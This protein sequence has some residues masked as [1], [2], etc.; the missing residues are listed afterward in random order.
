MLFV[1]SGA[2]AWDEESGRGRQ[3]LCRLPR[4]RRRQHEGRGGALS[5]HSRPAPTSRS[6]SKAASISA[7]PPTSRR[8]RWRRK[9]A[10]CWRSP[11]M[12]PS[13]RAAC[14]SRRRTI[15]SSRP[16]ARPGPSSTS[17]GRASSISPAPTATTTMP[18]GSW[19]ARPSRR[20]IRPAIRSIG[21]NGRRWARSSGGCATASS[22][23]APSRGIPGAPEYLALEAYLMDR[24]RGMPMDAPGVRP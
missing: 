2:A 19:P 20:P 10:S 1:Q 22:A 5:R 6:I 9:A 18:A 17:A 7:A 12:S 23:C 21:W 16:F 3:V 15:R 13:S 8:R 24:A 14:R 4:R 11:P